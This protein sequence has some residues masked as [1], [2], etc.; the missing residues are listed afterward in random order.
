MRHHHPLGIARRAGRVLQEENVRGAP[1][2][3]GAGAA[4]EILGDDPVEL[5]DVARDRRPGRR[6]ALGAMGRQRGNVVAARQDRGGLAVARDERHPVESRPELVRARRADGNRDQPGLRAGK[7]RADHLQT[8]RVSEQNPVVGSEPALVPQMPG[9]DSHAVQEAPVRVAF[10]HPAVH[11]EKRI[12]QLVR[13]F[14]RPVLE[15]AQNRVHL[16]SPPSRRRH[17]DANLRPGTMIPATYPIVRPDTPSRSAAAARTD[18]PPGSVR[19]QSR[20]ARG[21][22]RR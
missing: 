12:E 13:S 7:E 9:D 18:E 19:R 10:R 2:G 8:R 14:G 11:I 1:A 4:D 3:I 16:W 17:A 6:R 5:V 22:K 21:G 20:T 15:P